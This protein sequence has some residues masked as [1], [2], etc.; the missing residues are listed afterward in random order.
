MEYAAYLK[1]GEH[2]SDMFKIPLV[3][4]LRLVFFPAEGLDF[5]NTRQV[6]LKL[7]VQFSHL[8]LGFLEIRSDFAGKDYA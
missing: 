2:S 1:G 5:L 4:L 7:A 8:L 6:V 3:D